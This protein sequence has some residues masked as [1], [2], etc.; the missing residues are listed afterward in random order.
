MKTNPAIKLKYRRPTIQVVDHSEKNIRDFM[1]AIETDTFAGLRDFAFVNMMLDCG[2][3]PNEAL[4]IKPSDVNL[5]GRQIRVRR[6]YAKT[7]KERYLPISLQVVE[8]LKKLISVRPS[9]WETDV[10]V[11]CTYDGHRMP[12]RGMQDRFRKYSAKINVEI[13]PYH[14]RHVFGLFYVRKWR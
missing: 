14:L 8:V 12:A 2:I 4:Q 3:R 6:E 9:D 11:L 7:R 10:P 13:T 5:Q 1:N